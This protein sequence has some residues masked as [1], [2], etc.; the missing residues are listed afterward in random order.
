MTW[1]AFVLSAPG[2]R[3]DHLAA[4]VGQPID[5]IRRVRWQAG[6]HGRGRANARGFLELFTAFRGRAPREDEWPRPRRFKRLNSYEW[7]APEL[8]YLASLVGVVGTDEILRLLSTRLQRVTGDPTA[9]RTVNAVRVA[10]RRVGLISSDVVGGLTVQAAGRQVGSRSIFDHAIRRGDLRARRVGRYLVIPHEEFDRWKAG[11]VFPPVGYVRLTTLRRPL[12]FTSDKLPEWAKLGY[13]PT[14]IRCNPG[15]TGGPSTIFGTWWID[16]K[17]AKKL[18]ADRRAGRPMPWHG[19]VL[20]ENARV[21]WRRWQARKHPASCPSCRRIWGPSGAPTTF[22]DYLQRYPPLAFGAKRHLTKPWTPGLLFVEVARQA[23]LDVQTVRRAV[24]EGLLRTSTHDGRTYVTQTD[25]TRWISRGCPTGS[26]RASWLPVSS[27]CRQ[28]GFTREALEGYIASGRLRTK[29]Y[30]EG[31]LRG[32]TALLKQQ[33]RE[34]RDEIGYTEA[35][36]AKRAGVSIARLRVLLRETGWR[37][38]ARI[39]AEALHTAMKRQQSAHGVTIAEAARQLKRPRAWVEA[40]IRNGVAR[41]SRAPW[42]RGR[43]YLSGPQLAKLVRANRHPVTVRTLSAAWLLLG[44]AAS[45]AGVSV[46]TL[47]GWAAA[48]DLRTRPSSR[49]TRYHLR[50]VEARARHYWTRECRF[51]RPDVPAWLAKEQAA[52]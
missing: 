16:A 20:P 15:G 14:A 7:Q 1:Q 30:T 45:H 21:T 19:K 36:A 34:L 35:A 27:A 2:A 17:V 25:A 5:A 8:A 33:V 52:A 9:T 39:D 37:G 24:S 48:G 40:Q 38:A 26:R 50:S 47:M 23:R 42:A 22:E 51:R 32:E 3:L 11:R 28:Y 46:L 31:W 13:I 4:A 49:G 12:G 6:P 29:V 10:M 18:I 44:Q 43:R 41:V